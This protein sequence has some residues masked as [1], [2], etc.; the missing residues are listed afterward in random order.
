[1]TDGLGSQSYGYNSLSQL[2]SETRTFTGVGAFTLS[3][4]YNLA[5]E[6]KTLTDPWGATVNYGFDSTGRLNNVTGS[7]YGNVSQFLS[8]MQY[9][10]WGTLKS[11]TYGNGVT[12]SAGYNSRLQMTS[13]EVR[14]PNNQLAMSR[15]NQYYSDG[16]L[17]FSHDALDERFDRAAAY[18]HAARAV[19]AYSGSQARDFVYGTNSGT[20]TGPYR[21]SFQYN[22]FDQI[23]QQTNRLWSANEATTSTFANNRRQGWGYDAA[24]ELTSTDDISFNR[25]VTGEI[26]SEN[27][28]T[29]T[30]SNKFDGDGRL[31]STSLSRPNF[32]GVLM[33][34][35]TY[36]LNSAV[37]GGL[38]VAELNGS[39]QKT[40]GKIYAAGRKVAEG[41]AS[42]VGFAHEDP[43]NGSRSN[44]RPDGSYVPATEFTADGV[45]IGFEDPVTTSPDNFTPDFLG[46]NF[47]PGS[48]CSNADPNCMSCYLDGFETNCGQVANLMDIGAAEQC[49]DNDCGPRSIWDVKAQRFAGVLPLTTDPNT[50]LWMVTGTID[51]Y[52]RVGGPVIDLSDG[53]VIE[54]S[55]EWRRVGTESFTSFLEQPKPG[56]FLDCFRRSGLAT[57]YSTGP[58]DPDATHFT[59]E[60]AN[61]L[62]DAHNA[63]GTSLSLMAVTMMNENNSFSERPNPMVNVNSKGQAL[64]AKYWDVGPFQLNQPTI[65]AALENGVI[66]NAGTNY[67]DNGQIFGRTVKEKQPF[68]GDPLANARIAARW[69]QLAGGNDRQRAINY[70]QRAGRGKSYDRYAPLFDRF[71]NCYHR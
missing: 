43:V 49:P 8:K 13:F 6:L 51:Q 10:A 7:G 67:L 54:S 20:T 28:G 22:V 11:E 2:M 4:D 60:A 53:S 41:T 68:S 46:A 30:R 1:M 18:D 12:E 27:S 56:S 31:V 25:D 39:G 35:I 29:T 21:Q 38:A 33:T 45:D 69:L 24:G 48:E 40:I 64:P 55:S 32:R 3:Y 14:R 70:A 9:R 61:L 58:D 59:Q 34:T 47:G 50:G 63:E 71:F 36:Y 15:T 16:Q 57:N 37:L 52:S 65:R 44:S 5:G 66:K 17:Q 19:E 62:V 42:D 26:V 23:T